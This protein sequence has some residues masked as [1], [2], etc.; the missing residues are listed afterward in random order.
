V[1][2]KLM[3]VVCLLVPLV[4]AAGEGGGTLINSRFPE[5]VLQD[6]YDKQ[7]A[8]RQWEGRTVILI[9]SDKEGSEQN[10]AWVKAIRERYGERIVLQGIADVRSVPFFLKNRIKKKFQKD[11]E[12][13]LLDWDGVVFTSCGLKKNAPNIILIDK[14]GMMRHIHSGFAEPAAMARLFAEADKLLN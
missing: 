3:I 9:A 11:R 7:V 13:I 1:K 8:T 14:S 5:F 10:P 2:Q 12:S 4:A 6:Q